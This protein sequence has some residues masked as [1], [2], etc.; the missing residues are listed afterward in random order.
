MGVSKDQMLAAWNLQGVALRKARVAGEIYC[1]LYASYWSEALG[2]KEGDEV[3]C[4]RWSDDKVAPDHIPAIFVAVVP[5]NATTEPGRVL[6][7]LF[8]MKKD[9]FF[10]GQNRPTHPPITRR[11]DQV[12]RADGTPLPEL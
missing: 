2:L 1:Q 11:L 12:W 4:T 9:R 7:K 6:L 3:Q 5:P 10:A 8:A